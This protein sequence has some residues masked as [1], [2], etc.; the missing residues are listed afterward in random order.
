VLISGVFAAAMSSLDSS[1]NSMAS[2]LVND[3]YRRFK[4]EVDEVRALAIARG[5]TVILGALGTGA[6]WY[7]A[8]TQA[9]SLFDTYMKLLGMAGG[10]LAGVVALGMFTKRAS[11]WA[12]LGGAA[13][14]AFTVYV[15]NANNLTHFYLHGMIGFLVAFGVGYTLSLLGSLTSR[16]NTVDVVKTE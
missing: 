11:G 9:T 8:G 13:A 14:S 16:P 6:A 10:G 7:L 1:M 12:V 15:V 5:L 4:G 2:V 3:Y